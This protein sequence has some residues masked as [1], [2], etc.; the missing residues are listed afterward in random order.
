MVNFEHDAMDNE[1]EV[2]D[3]EPSIWIYSKAMDREPATPSTDSAQRG[4]CIT[5][6]VS[7][8]RVKTF[9]RTSVCY[10]NI[11]R[12]AFDDEAHVSSLLTFNSTLSP[13]ALAPALGPAHAIALRIR[14]RLFLSRPLSKFRLLTRTG[15]RTQPRTG[16]ETGRGLGRGLAFDPMPSLRRIPFDAIRIFSPIP[17]DDVAARAPLLLARAAIQTPTPTRALART[18]VAAAVTVSFLRIVI[19]AH[20]FLV[21]R[22]AF[23]V[24]RGVHGG[25]RIHGWRSS[26]SLTKYAYSACVRASLRSSQAGSAL[27]VLVALPTHVSL[28]RSSCHRARWIR[29]RSVRRGGHASRLSRT[30]LPPAPS[31]CYVLLAVAARPRARPSLSPIACR[32]LRHNTVIPPPYNL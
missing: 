28:A 2:S 14:I 4:R 5:P 3:T 12:A 18:C 10:S 27:L 22:T 29:R 9:A 32:S 8:V 24:Q 15:T 30:H 13:P 21:D 17:I 31:L 1:L 25:G 11:K 19:R 7:G 23:T 20:A 6:P 16:T 26:Y